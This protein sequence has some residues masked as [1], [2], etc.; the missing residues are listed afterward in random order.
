ME[1][2]LRAATVQL[3]N[4]QRR[5]GLRLLSLPQGDQARGIV[6][7][8]TEIGR[9]LTNALAYTG[10]TESTILLEEPETLDAELLQEEE[11]EAKT[12]VEK[13]RAHHVYGQVAVGRWGCRVRGGVEEGPDLGGHQNAH[14]L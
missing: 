11:A 5:F 2:G 6:G 3:E 7:A 12:E 8:P 1:S 10:R 14:G 13:D 9:S 4:R